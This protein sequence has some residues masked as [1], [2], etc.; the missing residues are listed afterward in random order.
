ML[1]LEHMDLSEA[2]ASAAARETLRETIRET[3]RETSNR[4]AVGVLERIQSIAWS[5]ARSEA[6]LAAQA[7]P[8]VEAVA[9]TI[10]VVGSFNKREGESCHRSQTVFGSC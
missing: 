6:A 7:A 1:G 8:H 2:A 3:L 9:S 10:A 5:N 4:D